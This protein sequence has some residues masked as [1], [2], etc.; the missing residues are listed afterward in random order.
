MT[1]DLL[2]IPHRL[3][4]SDEETVLDRQ[5]YRASDPFAFPKLGRPQQIVSFRDDPE[6]AV[7]LWQQRQAPSRG[8]H[9]T[10]RVCS[11]RQF[12]RYR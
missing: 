1:E 4:A 6:Y 5:R 11:S 2:D 7:L 9:T 8:T 10:K 3:P 12:G